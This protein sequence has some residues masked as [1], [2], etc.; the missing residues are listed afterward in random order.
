LAL[1]RQILICLIINSVTLTAVGTGQESSPPISDDLTALKV[2]E[3]AIQLGR[4]FP[5][6]IWPGYNLDSF[7][8]IVYVPDEWTLLVNAP[9]SASDF[10][11]CPDG[12]PELSSQVLYHQGQY[13]NLAGQ[14]AIDLQIDSLSVCAVA[15][16]GHDTDYF[17][18]FVAHENC[19]QFQ[20]KVFGDIPWEREEL[21]PIEDTENAALACLEAILL[22]DAVESLAQSDHDLARKRV[23]QLVAVR[24]HRWSRTDPYL[25][26]YEQ[27]QEIN[28]G[29][30]RYV[31][32]AALSYA[33]RL[34]RDPA[35]STAADDLILDLERVTISEYILKGLATL[36]ADN[37]IVPEDMPR[38]RIYPVGAAQAWLLDQLGVDWKPLAEQAGSQFTFVGL[39]SEAIEYDN[40]QTDQLLTEAKELHDFETIHKSSQRSIAAYLAGYDSAL[41]AFESQPGTRV[42]ISF[43]GTNLVRSRSSSAR[44]WLVDNGAM[45]YR[46]HFDIYVQRSLTVDDLPPELK[47]AGLIKPGN[48]FHFQL[49]DTG[50]LE[51]TN[52]DT[53]DKTL[54]FYCPEIESLIIA[55]DSTNI[56]LNSEHQFDSLELAGVGFELRT[57]R[58]GTISIAADR[59]SIALTP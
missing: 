19:H 47:D 31:E 52:W 41:A 15:Y 48:E 53:K 45:E 9:A 2:C 13:K 34:Q 57:A 17:L 35:V 51:I 14:L 54:A 18:G 36:I 50:L 22:H 40:H 20:H 38:N 46:D 12:W 21:Y 28:E 37:A 39:L 1:S 58:S 26:D 33:S 59:I 16:G 32:L 56:A 29:T 24:S 44:K 42:E 7:P 8:F 3:T 55:D 5:D 6:S 23:G 11:N 25:R 10:A 27:G 4:Q 49:K 43:N 30:A